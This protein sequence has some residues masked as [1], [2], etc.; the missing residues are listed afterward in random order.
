MYDP[1]KKIVE[2]GLEASKTSTITLKLR[3]P[4]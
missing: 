1:E 3:T 4:F 2:L